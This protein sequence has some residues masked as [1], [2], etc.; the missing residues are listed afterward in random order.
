MARQIED[1]VTGELFEV[2]RGRG[3]P[4][5][6]CAMSAAERQARYRAKKQIEALSQKQKMKEDVTLYEDLDL[7]T[8]AIYAVSESLDEDSRRR[9]W[10]AMGKKMGWM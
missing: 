4:S 7:E 9:A 6:G 8:L 1:K 2:R 10:L 3:R 5:T